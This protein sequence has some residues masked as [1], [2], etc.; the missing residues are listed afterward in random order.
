MATTKI[1][2]D[3][4]QVLA[5][6]SQIEN[7]NN[8]LLNLL[9]ESKATIDNLASFW[10]GQAADETRSSYESFASSY[11]QTYQDI[12]NQYVKFLRTNVAE[13]YTQTEMANTQLADAFK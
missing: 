7:D 10:S 6:A 9:N 1:I 13:Q 3:S 5:I 2:L 4:E 12:L 11:F 8:E